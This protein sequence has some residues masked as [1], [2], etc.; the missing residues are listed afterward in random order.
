MC[1][2]CHGSGSTGGADF[3]ALQM[4]AGF[5][6]SMMRSGNTPSSWD[7]RLQSQRNYLKLEIVK[8]R[9]DSGERSRVNDDGRNCDKWTIIDFISF[10]IRWA[11]LEK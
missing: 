11:F 2:F 5:S 4:P 6:A 8:G 1:H 3:L 10:S 7:F 9:S